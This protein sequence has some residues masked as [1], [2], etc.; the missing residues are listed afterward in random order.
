M[1]FKDCS[2]RI[3]QNR[4]RQD[5]ANSKYVVKKFD[6]QRSVHHDIFLQ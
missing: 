3:I 1:M 2:L 5:I 4:M 6:I